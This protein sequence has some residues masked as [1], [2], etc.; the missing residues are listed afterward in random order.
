M[1]SYSISFFFI[2]YF[3]HLFFYRIKQAITKKD[4]QVQ[5]LR[6]QYETSVKRA[7]HLESLLAQQRKLISAKPSSGSSASKKTQPS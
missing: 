3:N 1:K 6:I 5:A 4:E 7:E 2:N